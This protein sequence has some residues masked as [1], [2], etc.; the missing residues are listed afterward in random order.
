[1]QYT[2]LERKKK[3][4]TLIKAHFSPCTFSLLDESHLHKGHPG[5]RSGASHFA[6]TIVSSAFYNKLP[7]QRHRMIYQV[8][9]ALIPEE[10]HALKI[11]AKTPA[12]AD[13]L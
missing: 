4:E 13:L 3:I 5:A 8:L 2:A 1:M 12:E 7:I 6:L 11:S 9:Q 10:V